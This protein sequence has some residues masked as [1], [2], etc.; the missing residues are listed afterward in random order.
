L[1]SAPKHHSIKTYSGS[2]GLLMPHAFL[3]SALEWR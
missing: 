2:G 3:T 1:P